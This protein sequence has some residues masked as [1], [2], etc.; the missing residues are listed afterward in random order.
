MFSTEATSPLLDTNRKKNVNLVAN[1]VY[2]VITSK[3]S[4][5]TVSENIGP[6]PELITIGIVQTWAYILVAHQR[7]ATIAIMKRD[8]LQQTSNFSW[9][10]SR[11][12]ATISRYL[13]KR[14][15]W[16]SII[17]GFLTRAMM[18]FPGQINMLLLWISYQSILATE[19]ELI[20]ANCQPA[21]ATYNKV[22]ECG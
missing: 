19:L 22:W 13:I 20:R 21:K 3:M 15:S 1:I 10:I 11:L 17:G 7:F 5:Q 18:S 4:L 14:K 9:L 2:M 12:H 16:E 8:H 6:Q